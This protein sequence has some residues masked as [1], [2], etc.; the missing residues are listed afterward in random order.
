MGHARLQSHSRHPDCPRKPDGHAIRN[1]QSPICNPRSRVP[2]THSVGTRRRNPL[3]RLQGGRHA[4]PRPPPPW[5]P[6]LPLPRSHPRRCHA[7]RPKTG[8][9]HPPASL[10]PPPSLLHLRPGHPPPRPPLRRRH[11][12]S[13]RPRPHSPPHPHPRRCPPPQRGPS[14]VALCGTGAGQAG[15]RPPSHESFSTRAAAPALPLRA[16]TRPARSP[17]PFNPLC[18]TG[19]GQAANRP[20]SHNCTSIL[21]GYTD[22]PSA[23][24]S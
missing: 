9:G 20:S 11:Q 7:H 1:P 23:I 12:R 10:P 3:R 22:C 24:A 4:L 6:L 17:R 13:G 14:T 18:R 19:A 15:H 2:I 21:P 5:P 8:R 16:S